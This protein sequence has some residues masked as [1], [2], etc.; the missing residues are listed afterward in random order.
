MLL[1][2]LVLD[3]LEDRL[4][5][6]VDNPSGMEAVEDLP[7]VLGGLHEIRLLL[8][9]LVA[10][11]LREDEPLLSDEPGVGQIAA[12]LGVRIVPDGIR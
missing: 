3:R 11:L 4:L 8:G 6:Q 1:D 5:L 12:V 7:G 2:L 10:V 9:E